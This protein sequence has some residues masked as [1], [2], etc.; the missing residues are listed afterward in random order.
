M[1][2]AASATD[3]HLRRELLLLRAELQRQ[4]FTGA[5][6]AVRDSL[7]PALRAGEFLVGLTRKAPV[8][9]GLNWMREH[10]LAGS[11]VSLLVARLGGATT[12]RLM[13]GGLM[14]IGTLVL[15]GAALVATG[16]V[17]ARWWQRSHKS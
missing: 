1:S 3:R 12:R 9:G 10:P 7:D 16:L 8:R 11:L 15:S 6:E 13:T 14:R 2:K 17:A 4:E 5:A